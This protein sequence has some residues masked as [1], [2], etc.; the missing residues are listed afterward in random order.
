MACCNVQSPS[1]DSSSPR[2][3]LALTASAL[4][5]GMSYVMEF[6]DVAQ[7]G[8]MDTELK[9]DGFRES[10]RARPL[11]AIPPR[12]SPSRQA[13][14]AAAAAASAAPGVVVDPK[15]LMFVFGMTLDY[16]DDLIGGGFKFNNPNAASTCG[17]GQSFGA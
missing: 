17:C 14:P 11:P 1:L 9:F 13:S 3:L 5:S 15:S 6:E 12:P 2:P 16:S 7:V 8:A 10:P 4:R